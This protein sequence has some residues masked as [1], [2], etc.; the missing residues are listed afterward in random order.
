[1]VHVYAA[2]NIKTA[3]LPRFGGFDALL[4]RFLQPAE[5]LT[6]LRQPLFEAGEVLL[7]Q[8]VF[9]VMAVEKTN[10]DST[11]STWLRWMRCRRL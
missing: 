5:I 1:M 10:P 9:V 2:A 7:E 3:S 4:Y 11:L 6:E 8:G